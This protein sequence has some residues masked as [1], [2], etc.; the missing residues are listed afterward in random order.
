MRRLKIILAAVILLGFSLGSNRVMGQNQGA[1]DTLFY[2][3]IHYFNNKDYKRALEIFRLLDRVYDNHSRLT[4]SLLMQGK[5]YYHID[6]Y[7]QSLEKFDSII[8]DFPESDY[9]DDALYNKMVVY[10]KMN[11][12]KKA[13]IHGMKLLEHGGD[14]RVLKKGADLSALLMKTKM[15]ISELKELLNEIQGERGKAAVTL[16][17][18]YKEIN[19]EHYQTVIKFIHQFLE[20]YPE[21]KYRSRMETLLSKAERLGR[22][23]LKIGVLLPLSGTYAEQGNRLLNGIRFA[24]DKFNQESGNSVDI[25]SY[26]SE[27]N[28]VK[29]IQ[30]AKEL[31]ENAEIVA[32]IGEYDDKITAAV[33]GIT[34]SFGLPLIAPTAVMNGISTIGDGVFQPRSTLDM[35]GNI[36]ADY[37]VK[38]LGLKT[39]A[40][41]GSGDEYGKVLRNAFAGTV[42]GLGG[43]IVA[44]QWYYEGA[45]QLKTQ[46]EEI[47][48]AGIQKMI[49]DSLIIMVS[50]EEW[51]KK[52]SEHQ[53]Q[54]GTLYVRKS[55]QALVDSTELT[56]TSI[57]AIFLP[58]KKEALVYVGSQFAFFNIDC[59]LFGSSTWYDE[60]FLHKYDSYIKGIYFVTDMFTDESNYSYIQFKNNY[61]SH[62]GI[63]PAK[64]DIIGY[65]SA[66]LILDVMSEEIMIRDNIEKS[67]SEIKNF[68]GIGVDVSFN[69]T[70]V[71]T[72]LPLLQFNGIDVIQIK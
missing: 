54:D 55:L 62:Y 50:K 12:I 35:Q 28:I 56:V 51:E 9:Y 65:D 18:A 17:I 61:R 57:D 40:I 59:R 69:K 30:I 47:R 10:Y 39:F 68:R 8:K 44:E 64:M 46:F 49:E 70:G 34:Q 27:S 1:V 60:E 42:I 6:A 25:I 26:D 33:A 63:T 41:L 11:M 24:V 21:S 72:R 22:D 29:A 71:N 66:S 20:L 67:L 2:E 38:G 31:G 14:E 13:V 23:K 53:F 37:A 16:Q 5:S 7:Q 3:G 58:V 36:L 43:E 19:E 4:A 15:S 45:E 48:K 32:V 52:Y